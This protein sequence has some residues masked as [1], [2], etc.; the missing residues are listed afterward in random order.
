[1]RDTDGNVRRLAASA[2]GKIRDQRAVEPLLDLLSRETKP[3]VRQY[4]VKA[5]GKI[6]DARARSVLDKIANDPTERE[7][8]RTSACQA[9]KQV[10]KPFADQGQDEDDIADFLNRSHPRELHGPWAAGWALDFHS[11]FFGADWTRSQ[12][13]DLAYRFKYEGQRSLVETLADQLA[14]LVVEQPELAQADAI[15]PVPPSSPRAFDPVSALCDALGKRLDRPVWCAL[16]KTR[17]TAPQKEMRTLAQKRANVAG[18]FIVTADRFREVR[19]K[20]LLV[21]DD[22]Y[23][24]GATL[25]EITC[26]LQRASVS[27]VLVLTLTRTIHADA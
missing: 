15:V 22:L 13:G 1:L 9:L 2:L 18:A 10:I 3:Q 12:A 14:A 5:L 16:A 11:R 21:L 8:T 24:S 26:T 25:E 20:R 4:A 27:A 7:Y 17:V 6:G 19:G 23:D